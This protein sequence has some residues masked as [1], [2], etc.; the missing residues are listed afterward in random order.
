LAKFLIRWLGRSHVRA[1]RLADGVCCAEEQGRAVRAALGAQ[2][3]GEG[4]KGAAE[5]GRLAGDRDRGHALAQQL[6]R[7][8]QLPL[9]TR[10]LPEQVQCPADAPLVAEPA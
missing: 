1:R 7:A 10:P 9:L 6:L 8:V 4:L 3:R 2:Y 5:Y